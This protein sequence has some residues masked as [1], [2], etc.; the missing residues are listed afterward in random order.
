MPLHKYP[1]KGYKTMEYPL[2]HQ[3][4]YSF[5]LSP[6]TATKNSTMIRLIMSRENNNAVD[7]IEV[8]PSHASFAEET[9][10]IVH[11]DSIIPRMNIAMRAQMNQAMDET[12]KIR[13]IKF[14]WMPIYASFLDSYTAM[15]NETNVEV[16]DIL[17]LK[18]TATNKTGFP[19]FN[20]VK[21]LAGG[22][23]PMSTVNFTEVY[24]TAGMDTDITAEGITFDPDL[25]WDALNHYSNKGMLAKVMGQWH[26]EILDVRR[27]WIRNSNNFTHPTVKRGNEYTFCGIL[28]HVPLVDSI[29]QF[30]QV[31]DITE[32]S[33][34][35]S[36]DVRVRYDEWNSQFDQT[37]FLNLMEEYH[38]FLL[39]YIY[40]LTT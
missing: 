34:V 37:A 18:T 12:D 29:D 30:Y 16:E 23:W 35:I 10:C 25:M 19:L 5:S 26:T 17:E 2:P 15:D 13:Y 6:E 40:I 20:N 9:G 8:N 36:F 39:T 27:P 24:G 33:S 7:T 3:F 1:P 32:A 22:N 31:G 28:F 14:H 21:L 4:D 38:L 11:P